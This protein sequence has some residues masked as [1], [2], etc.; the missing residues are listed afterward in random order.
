MGSM[1][2]CRHRNASR[3]LMQI[4]NEWHNWSADDAED[5]EEAAA[6]SRILHQ[7]KELL[8]MNGATVN[9]DGTEVNNYD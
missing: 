7:C 2:Y 4:V 1:S 5:Q 6:R 9:T 8:E 3:E